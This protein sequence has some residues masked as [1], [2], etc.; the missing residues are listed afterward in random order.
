M[1]AF[2]YESSSIQRQREEA[3]KEEKFL[4]TVSGMI[5]LNTVPMEIRE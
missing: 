3:E 4:E 5:G 2:Q 1:Q